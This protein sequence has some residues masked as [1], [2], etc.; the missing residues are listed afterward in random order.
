ML[1]VDDQPETLHIYV[2]RDEV[3]RPQL[4]PIFLSVLALASLVALAV[5]FPYQQPVMRATIRVP[6]VLLPL[7]TF[8]AKVAVIPT[9]VKTYP[10]TTAHGILTIT[11]GSVISQTIPQGF[12]LGNV[13]TDSSVFVPAGSANGYGYATVAAHALIH[14]KAGNIPAYTINQVE[15][16][17]V[18][19]RNL[20]SFR[21]GRDGYSVKVITPKDRSVATAKAR[22]TLLTMSFGL[23]YPC[24][25]AFSVNKRAVHAT[26]RCQFVAYQ[27]PP[28][29]HV[30]GVRIIGRNLLLSVWFVPRPTRLWVK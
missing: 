2:V 4:Y 15:G 8:T 23:H 12:R 30:T 3:P 7:K 24:N 17:S 21:G 5:V 16:S 6:A 10:A 18:Y 14:G 25:E 9:G 20:L 13:I 1:H 11:N 28:F 22:D 29:M 19:I 27:L 26:W